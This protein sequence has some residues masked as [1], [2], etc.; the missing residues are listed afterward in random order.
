M[1]CSGTRK[2]EKGCQETC[3]RECAEIDYPGN[4]NGKHKPALYFA[5]LLTAWAKLLLFVQENE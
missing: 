3:S 2:K 1:G 5:M 4:S